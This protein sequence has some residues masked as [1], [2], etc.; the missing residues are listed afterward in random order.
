MAMWGSASGNIASSHL[1]RNCLK[2]P[3][4]EPFWQITVCLAWS[5][6]VQG[7]QRARYAYGARSASG[8]SE[9]F[10][11]IVFPSTAPSPGARPDQVRKNLA[12]AVTLI[13]QGEIL[14]KS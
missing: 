14:L 12:S 1:I 13:N 10:A 3:L 11:S 7:P 8:R 4:C 6:V 5:L 2:H 9:T